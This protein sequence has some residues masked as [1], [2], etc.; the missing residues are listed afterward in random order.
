MTKLYDYYDVEYNTDGNRA[1]V[2][3]SNYTVPVDE[4]DPVEGCTDSTATNYNANADTDD[5]S[6]VFENVG[7]NPENNATGE[8]SCVGICDE[9]V[10][11]QAESDESDPVFVLTIVMVIIFMAAITVIIVSKDNEDGQEVDHEEITDTFI[12]ELPPLEPPKN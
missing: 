6:C 12:P 8:D 2:E 3:D 4:P 7:E 10:S 11:D 5:G 1:F 9:D